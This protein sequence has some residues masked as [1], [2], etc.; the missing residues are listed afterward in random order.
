MEILNNE[1]AKKE[2]FIGLLT[3]SQKILTDYGDTSK[4]ALLEQQKKDFANFRYRIAII[5]ALNRG[6]TTLLNTMLGIKDDSISPIDSNVCTAA[7]IRYIDKSFNNNK[8]CLRVSFNDG[9]KPEE[10]TFEKADRFQRYLSHVDRNTEAEKVTQIEVF[11]DFPLV[12]DR[13][14]FIDTPGMGSKWDNDNAL[15]DFGRKVADAVLFLTASN[16]PFDQD[17]KD[18]L[19]SLAPEI[20]KK[21]IFVLTKSDRIDEAAIIKTKEFIKKNLVE[22][23]IDDP[24]IIYPVGAGVV[25]ELITNGNNKKTM[26]ILQKNP[27]KIKNEIIETLNGKSDEEAVSILKEKFGIADLEQAIYDTIH[28]EDLFLDTMKR[29]SGDMWEYFKSA[30]T[31][32]DRTHNEYKE[33]TLPELEQKVKSLNEAKLAF[34][35]DYAQIKKRFCSKWDAEVSYLP[36]RLDTAKNE[37]KQGLDNFLTITNPLLYKKELNAITEKLNRCIKESL[38][39]NIADIEANLTETVS[40]LES[41]IAVAIGKL[42]DIKVDIDF[43]LKL[44]DIWLSSFSMLGAGV[45]I[46]G[47]S[48]GFIAAAIIAFV[49]AKLAALGAGSIIVAVTTWLG[50]GTGEALLTASAVLATTLAVGIPALV[51][52]IGAVVFSTDFMKKQFNERLLKTVK[53]KLDKIFSEMRTDIPSTLKEIRTDYISKIDAAL[54]EEIKRQKIVLDDVIAEKNGETGRFEALNKKIRDYE[55]IINKWSDFCG[56]LQV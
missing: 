42:F 37:I 31:E 1:M 39:R 2:K 8:E 14:V 6:K 45:A 11:G 34:E 32:F 53:E 13:A 7:V 23:G 26:G 27:Y 21:L 16:M 22:I 29:K 51:L 20:R 28:R 54:Q 48:M 52:G 33:K 35:S 18:L 17:E 25:L 19:E 4:A 3:G 43:T 41:E 55:D 12:G 15:S 50:I 30:K 46:G 44:K 10:F 38:D 9:R 24:G 5:G 36:G 40:Q 49:Q 47:T 56:E